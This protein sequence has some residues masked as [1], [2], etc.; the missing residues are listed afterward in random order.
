MICI[1]RPPSFVVGEGSDGIGG[2]GG[3]DPLQ[4]T[5]VGSER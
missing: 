5:T 4:S 3:G 1:D 2:G